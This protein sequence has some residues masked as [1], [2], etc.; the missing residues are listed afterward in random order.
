VKQINAAIKDEP[1]SLGTGHP[2]IAK[3]REKSEANAKKMAAALAKDVVPMNFQCS[4][5]VVRDELAKV[6]PDFQKPKRGL[7]ITAIC[8]SVK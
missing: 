8:D 3:L 1:F 5:R 2:W 6:R 7:N 4:L